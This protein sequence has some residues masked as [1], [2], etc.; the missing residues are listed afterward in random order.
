M[1]D[2]KGLDRLDSECLSHVSGSSPSKRQRGVIKQCRL[3][4]RSLDGRGGASPEL[5]SQSSA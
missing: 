2:A 5:S 4:G 3:A 1:Q